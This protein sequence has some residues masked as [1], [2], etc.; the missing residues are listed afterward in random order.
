MSDVKSSLF[1][2]I[3]RTVYTTSSTSIFSVKII[4]VMC[5]RHGLHW[6]DKY[7]KHNC[8]SYFHEFKSHTHMQYMCMYF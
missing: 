8:F 1:R 7:D 4:N 3:V 6:F 5:D 2:L